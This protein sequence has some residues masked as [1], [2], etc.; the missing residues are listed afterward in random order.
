VAAKPGSIDPGFAATV[1][2]SLPISSA[3]CA[4]CIGRHWSSS[5]V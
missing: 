4:A 2:L 3:I 1:Q 5:I